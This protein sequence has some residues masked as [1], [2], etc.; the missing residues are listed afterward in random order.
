MAFGVSRQEAEA[1]RR[2]YEDRVRRA[3]EQVDRE[4]EE[5]RARAQ[6]HQDIQRGSLARR[7]AEQ[8]AQRSIQSPSFVDSQGWRRVTP[9]GGEPTPEERQALAEAQ[10]A[11]YDA[12]EAQA[13]NTVWKFTARDSQRRTRLMS[14]RQ[15]LASNSTFSPEQIE[16]GLQQIDAQIESIQKQA[17]P[18]GRDEPYYP[19]GSPGDLVT[20]DGAE[21][22]VDEK[23]VLKLLVR[24][25][26]TFRYAEMLAEAKRVKETKDRSLKRRELAWDLRQETTTIGMKGVN[27]REESKFTESEIKREIYNRYPAETEEELKEKHPLTYELRQQDAPLDGQEDLPAQEPPQEPQEVQAAREVL[28]D[29]KIPYHADRTKILREAQDVIEQWEKGVADVDKKL[30]VVS[31]DADWEKLASGQ[32]FRDSEGIEWVKK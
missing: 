17:F 9:Y 5:S 18:R 3:N 29:P 16:A 15:D 21:F 14:A 26:Q 24:P 7:Q 31:N 27:Q 23:G 10:M 13:R 32:R 4:R 8:D 22:V 12:Q 11:E 2:R 6:Q 30:P 20:K 1:N 25:N 19:N 28:D